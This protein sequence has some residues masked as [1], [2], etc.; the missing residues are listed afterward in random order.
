MSDPPTQSPTAA[1]VIEGA[2]PLLKI[3]EER[4]S[5][6]IRHI[7]D[8]GKLLLNVLYQL[9]R[10]F[11]IYEPTNAVFERPLEEFDRISKDLFGRMGE[12][13]LLMVE[14]QPYLGDLRI[15][16]DSTNATLIMFLVDWLQGLGLGGWSFSPAPDSALVRSFFY[17]VARMKPSGDDPVAEI[18]EW[19]LREGHG[20]AVP[21]PPQRFREEGEEQLEDHGATATRATHVFEHGV[22]AVRGF[23]GMLEKAGIGSALAARKAIN[24]IVDM[25]DEGGQYALAISLLTDLD[26]PLFT[27]S[28]HVA[29]LS[30]AI[31]RQL[32][33]PRELLAELGLC[34]LFHDTGFGE[35]PPD[36]GWARDAD[37]EVRSLN[38]PLLGFRV[39]LRQRGYHEGRMLRAVVNLEHHLEVFH[40]GQD[41]WDDPRVP[42]HPF[43]RIVGA[44]DAY[45]TLCNDTGTRKAFL[46][47]RALEELW[48][49]RGTRF[50]H[51]VVQ[52]LVNIMGK[53]PFGTLLE[54]DDGSLVVVVERT[55]SP[56]SF[57]RP[58]V[59]VAVAGSQLAA[60]E[61]FN[62]GSVHESELTV[63]S[64]HD[65]RDKGIELVEVLFPKEEAD[66]E[67]DPAAETGPWVTSGPPSPWDD[68]PAVGPSQDPDAPAPA[69]WL[70]Q[71]PVAG[72]EDPFTTS[73]PPLPGEDEPKKKD[74]GDDGDQGSGPPRPPLG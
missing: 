73:A 19:A 59:K 63:V 8:Q 69:P 33:V 39:Q 20:W 16:Q 67:P 58:V 55:Q 41:A 70:Q 44:A 27:H 6:E 64:Y 21:H 54:L 15:R 28:M 49:G 25:T 53:Y 38:H 23:F 45:E 22:A 1:P 4:E 35:L 74:P 12:V 26:N 32:G 24:S 66:Q 61:L 57:E 60:G 10:N 2:D 17:E 46:P 9:V 68:S 40:R 29:N 18:Q 34:G 14:S 7:R 50:D 3:R 36:F 51:A 30:V 62:L 56:S 48:K 52:A 42:I 31:G 47:P 11:Q 72:N 43:S 71:G 65:P 13:Q 37:P 5:G